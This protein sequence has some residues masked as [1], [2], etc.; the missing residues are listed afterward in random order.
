[1]YGF[2]NAYMASDVSAPVSDAV[3]LPTGYTRTTELDGQVQGAGREVTLLDLPPVCARLMPFAG[4]R[5][6]KGAR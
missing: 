3:I 6:A 4:A 2:R 5:T 1:M